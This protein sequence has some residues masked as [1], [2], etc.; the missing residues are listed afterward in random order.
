MQYWLMLRNCTSLNWRLGCLLR[1]SVTLYKIFNHFHFSLISLKRKYYCYYYN[2]PCRIIEKI[3]YDYLY[4]SLIKMSGM[5]HLAKKTTAT[6][7]EC[8]VW[9][10]KN[11]SMEITNKK[12]MIS[13][14]VCV[15]KR[16]LEDIGLYESCWWISYESAICFLLNDSRYL[17][18]KEKHSL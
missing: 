1:A 12:S 3:K 9:V 16:E 14:T 7:R 2:L 8:L 17:Q 18:R 15:Y 6:K 11:K 5:I 13:T 10:F 4:K